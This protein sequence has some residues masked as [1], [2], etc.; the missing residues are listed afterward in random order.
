LRGTLRDL[1]RPAGGQG[2]NRGRY[3]EADE[4][5]SLLAHAVVAS[6]FHRTFAA[7]AA[8]S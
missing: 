3:E 5:G 6:L 4:R 8:R 2:Q 7:G 1:G